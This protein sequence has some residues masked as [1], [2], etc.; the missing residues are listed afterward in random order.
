MSKISLDETTLKI[1]DV[2]SRQIG[3][4]VS[5]NELKNKIE[6]SYGSANYS[7]IYSKIQSLTEEEITTLETAGKAS[8]VSLNFKNWFTADLLSLTDIWRKMEVLKTHPELQSLVYCD[9]AF[10]HLFHRRVDQDQKLCSVES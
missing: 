4:T 7:G 6:E 3:K 10:L 9:C 2:L 5:I 8:L 1:V